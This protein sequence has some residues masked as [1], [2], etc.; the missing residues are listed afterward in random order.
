MLLM[1][2]TCDEEMPDG[3]DFRQGNFFYFAFFL[4]ALHMKTTAGNKKQKIT[5]SR[6]FGYR[7]QIDNH[8]TRSSNI[9]RNHSIT[10]VSLY[11]ICVFHVGALF[12]N[13]IDFGE[14]QTIL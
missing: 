7:L 9:G 4:L 10:L 6:C 3:V 8:N 5:F 13:H 14:L 2:S 11:Y 12:L 1:L